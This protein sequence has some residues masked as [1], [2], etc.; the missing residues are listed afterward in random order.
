MIGGLPCSGGTEHVEESSQATKLPCTAVTSPRRM[1]LL[2]DKGPEDEIIDAAGRETM[3]GNGISSLA[4]DLICRPNFKQ[5]FIY[6]L[7][8]NNNIGA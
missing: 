1:Q 2:A 7:M 4:A 8:R 5:Q 6:I 3:K